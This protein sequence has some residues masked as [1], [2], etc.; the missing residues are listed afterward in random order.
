MKSDTFYFLFI[1]SMAILVN[2]VNL[3]SVIIEQRKF[4]KWM[5]EQ[6]AK[7][8]EIWKHDYNFRGDNKN[9]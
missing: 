6:E 9:D 1:S 7:S 4:N 8:K 2:I 5:K 3:I